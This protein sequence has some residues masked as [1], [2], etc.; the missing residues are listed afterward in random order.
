MAVPE[1]VTPNDV[2]GYLDDTIIVQLTDDA[3][4]GEIDESVLAE[5]C[6]RANREVDG[7][8]STRYAVLSQ[9]PQI[10]RDLA[11]DVAIYHLHSRRFVAPDNIA[12]RYKEA[13]RKLRE[14]SEGRLEIGLAHKVSRQ[15]RAGKVSG[16]ERNFDPESMKV[17]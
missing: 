12:D 6:G 4:T 10:L 11:L 9:P 16:T 14:I 1:Y 13:L 17:M 3:G 8:V 15:T 5:V 7:Y 2:K